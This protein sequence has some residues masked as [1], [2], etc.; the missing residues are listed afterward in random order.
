M[1]KLFLIIII[2]STSTTL[3]AQQE[4]YVFKDANKNIEERLSN[5]K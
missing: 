1:K 4:Y 3:V 2:C 5:L